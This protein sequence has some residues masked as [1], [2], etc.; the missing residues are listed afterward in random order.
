MSFEKKKIERKPL[1]NFDQ[2]LCLL[3]NVCSKRR[4][5]QYRLKEM[6]NEI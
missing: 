6:S 3:S 5:N 2:F 1:V 4:K